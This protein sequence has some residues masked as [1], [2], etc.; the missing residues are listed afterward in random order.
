MATNKK[1]S[2]KKAPTKS[3]SAVEDKKP[4]RRVE[5]YTDAPA[6]AS[7]GWK[8]VVTKTASGRTLTT[9]TDPIGMEDKE[10][11]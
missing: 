8:E 7:R 2:A 9:Y 11:E 10:A 3:D 4:S 5:S 6:P 1:S